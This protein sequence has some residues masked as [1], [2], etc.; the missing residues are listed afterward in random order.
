VQLIAA[1]Q[2][3]DG[4][5]GTEAI[6]TEVMDDVLPGGDVQP[7]MRSVLEEAA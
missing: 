4:W 5:S 3:P 6:A 2:W 1:N 7:V